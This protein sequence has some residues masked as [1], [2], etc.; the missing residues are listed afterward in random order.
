MQVIW[1]W[2]TEPSASIVGIDRRRVRLLASL[3]VVLIGL[4]T[5]S[6]SI[7]LA[8]V[9]GF[10]ATFAIIMVAVAIL[11]AAW[12]LLR[13]ARYV[14]AAA[15]VSVLPSVASLAAAATNPAD[16]MALAFISLGVVLASF[17]LSVRAAAT[18]GAV[19][20]ATISV[21]PVFQPGL[22]HATV[23][24]GA[25]F[26]AIAA[27]LVVMAARHRDAVESARLAE[28]ARLHEQLLRADRLAS[29]GM[30]AAG[31]AH[32]IR[33]PLT[34]V[35][36][37]LD[38]LERQAGT[39]D[40]KRWIVDAGRG[41]ERI[42]NLVRGLTGFA[43]GTDTTNAP[44][45]VRAALETA[46]AIADSQIR[47]RARLV[48]A[49]AEVPHARAD[50]VRLEQVFLNLLINAAQSIPDGDPDLH[51]IRVG[52]ALVGDDVEVS[53]IDTGSGIPEH[54]LSAIFEPFVSTKAHTEGTGLG[55]AICRDIITSFGG[56]IDVES[57]LGIGTTFRVAIPVVRDA[58]TS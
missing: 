13:A 19:V 24:A 48:R 57:R 47:H 12:L 30:L 51:E 54:E 3:L 36:A 4:G 46:L 26:N 14:A 7:Q 8:L 23:L 45:D 29:L 11:V 56:R 53:V 38:L 1:R 42:S 25:L 33:N 31:I 43:R 6:A 50:L 10:V 58:T 2:L 27:C 15:I 17:L 21:L 32:E 18:L 35:G 41:V 39:T 52:I 40:A 34:Y 55:L 22:E 28:Q 16:P 9:P 49:Y 20:V 5:A 37:N 44:A